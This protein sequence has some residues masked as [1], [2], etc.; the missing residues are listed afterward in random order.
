MADDQEKISKLIVDVNLSVDRLLNLRGDSVASLFRKAKRSNRKLKL[1]LIGP[2]GSGKTMSALRI[3]RGL[4]CKKIAVID[5]ENGSSELYEGLVLKEAKKLGAFEFD[6]AVMGAPFLVS[7]YLTAMKEAVDEG[8]D[9]VIV[10]SMTHAWAGE[11]GILS[12]KEALDQRGGNSFTNWGKLTPEQ[13]ALK[14][15]V[16]THPTHLI[17]TMRTKT[18][19]VVEQNEKGKSA[20]KKV[21]L[22]P[23]QREG[24]E[25]EFDVVFEIAMD[26]N[27]SASKDRTNM[28]D[29]QFFKVTE[30]TGKQL[31][32]WLNVAPQEDIQTEAPKLLGKFINSGTA[33]TN[34]TNEAPIIP[35]IPQVQTGK[36]SSVGESSEMTSTN[37]QHL[38]ARKAQLFNS[39][40]T[41]A[42]NKRWTTDHI[43]EAIT[44][45]FK[46]EAG[47]L[48]LDELQELHDFITEQSSK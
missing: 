44:F 39:I 28:F 17:C 37:E 6:V 7:K 21:G 11:G 48:S 22:A 30:E 43:K 34:H 42:N 40:K 41:L 31:H 47:Q 46:K 36:P 32:D 29:N 19:Y 3:L 23:V 10:D 8:Y 20:P 27:A 35:Q 2:S 5:T 38:N 24:F 12:R 1:A 14:N 18:E 25:Y 45:L 33:Q 9:G 4:G 15:A 16:L 26:H 13:E